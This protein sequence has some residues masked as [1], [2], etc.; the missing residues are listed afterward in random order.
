MSGSWSQIRRGSRHC[1]DI[2]VNTTESAKVRLAGPGW[3][4]ATTL[5]CTTED[6]IATTKTSIIDQRPTYSTTS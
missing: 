1:A 3:I 2:I 4:E 5:N 6:R